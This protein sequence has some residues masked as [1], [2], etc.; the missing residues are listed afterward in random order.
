[1]NGKK[2]IGLI[3]QDVE[4]VIPDVVESNQGYKTISYDQIIPFT[5]SAIQEQQKE[6]NELRQQLEDKNK[7]LAQQEDRLNT[8]EAQVQL[9]TQQINKNPGTKNLADNE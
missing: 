4:Q 7:A 3:A 8:L 9:L 5:V 2:R 6:I 1:M